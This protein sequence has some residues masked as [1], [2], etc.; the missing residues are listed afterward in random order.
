MDVDTPPGGDAV[1]WPASSLSHDSS[2]GGGG[3]GGNANEAFNSG[4][5]LE[6]D[7][8]WPTSSLS[9]DSSSGCGGSAARR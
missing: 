3:L 4:L 5:G 7:L 6:G 2:S 9:H 1:L 8:P